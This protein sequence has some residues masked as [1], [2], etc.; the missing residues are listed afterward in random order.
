M[1]S[2]DLISM[3]LGSLFKRKI[4]TCLTI[5]GVVIG[6]ASIVIMVSLGIGLDRQAMEMIAEYG[7]LTQITVTPGGGGMDMGSRNVGGSDP[8][9]YLLTSK[10]V[11][12]IASMPHISLVS[13]ILYVD[14]VIRGGRYERSGQVKAMSLEALK[15]K[16]SDFAE[17][18]LPKE[19]DTLAFIFGNMVKKDF[20]DYKTK[21]GF[22][23]T[24]KMP[25]IDFMKSPLFTIFDVEA[26]EEAKNPDS[27]QSNSGGKEEN[28]EGQ[29]QK[30][31]PPKKYLV[32]AAGV[33]KGGEEDYFQYS[34][35]V[36]CDI[37]AI[38][39]IITKVFRGRPI[40]GQPTNKNG[41][42]YREIF[43]NELLVIVDN[44]DSM[45]ETETA[46]R[47]MGYNSYSNT[48][49]VEEERQSARQRQALLGGVGA[50]SLLVAAIGISNTMLMSIYERTREIGVMK[51]LGCRLMDIQLLF[52][53]EAGLIG[54]IGGL[55][56]NL[57]S[58]AISFI[59]N[60]ITK[61]TTSVIP[62]WL[63]LAGIIFSIFVSI[64]AGYIPSRRAMKLSPL[65][66][67][68]NE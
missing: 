53:C 41:K 55:I 43:Y 40:P 39:P 68:R 38:T 4:R 7:G 19:G 37:E 11:K 42:P 48:E 3:S 31:G 9:A 12:D 16:Y 46:I 63:A 27:S 25:N 15:E 28:A 35:D 51:V 50:V 2:S 57:L 45:E 29:L 1:R 30:K 36:C 49:W 59:I 23:D 13:P 60:T 54:L 66:A 61:A 58:F 64:F 24:G 6:I 22:W 18:G 32:P 10:S 14:A 44:V 34:Y 20:V 52:L 21:A 67:I 26:Y 33:L 62:G 8:T 47:Q 65:S 56:G 17:G 5:L